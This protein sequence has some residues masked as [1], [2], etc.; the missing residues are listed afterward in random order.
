MPIVQNRFLSHSLKLLLGSATVCL[1]VSIFVA[2]MKIAVNGGFGAS[3]LRPFILW[4]L[5]FAVVITSLKKG[6]ISIFGRLSLIYR[7]V[8]ASVLGIIGGTLWTYLVALSLGPWFGAFS[9]PVLICW[10]VG[11]ASGMVAGIG[12][13]SGKKNFMII[14]I[15]IIAIIYI[16]IAIGANPLF[17]Y[18]SGD[19]Q[20]EVISFK[21]TLGLEPL[22]IQEVLANRVS[23]DN[24]SQLKSLGFTG[25][26]TYAGGSGVVGRGNKHARA[27][28]IMQH[29]LKEPIDLHQPDGV[30][31]I[32]IQTND[33]WKMIPSDAPTLQRVIHLEADKRDPTWA[34]LYSVERAD[35]S[36]QGGTLFTWQ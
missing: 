23:E 1:L 3:D 34:T 16:S 35:G 5:P 19:Q 24:L 13:Y 11:G 25:Q 36:R 31:V 30:E 27:I 14:E 29:Q 9:F 2:V 32:Y 6:L 22:D 21:W 15:A 12:D 7:Y 4:T 20:L 18:L 8:V 26:L 33:G 17:K 28:I 10:I